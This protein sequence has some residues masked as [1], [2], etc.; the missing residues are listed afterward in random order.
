MQLEGALAE[1]GVARRVA[2]AASLQLGGCGMRCTFCP[3]ERLLRPLHLQTLLLK[4]LTRTR[5]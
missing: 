3:Q 4:L 2:A 5:R 1:E